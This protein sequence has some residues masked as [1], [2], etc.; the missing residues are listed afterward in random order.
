MIDAV[1][2]LAFGGPTRPEEIRPFLENVARG[3]NIPPERLQEVAR[4]YEM[5]PGGRSPL[6]ALT[7]AQ[8][9]ALSA[10]LASRG[11]ALPVFLGMRHWHPFIE[12]TLAA[13]TA[14]GRRRALA[15]IL[16]SLRTE[17]SWDRYVT[18][19]EEA[20]ARIRG[21]PQ[22]TFAPA[23]NEHAGFIAAVVDRVRRALREVPAAERGQTPLVFTAHSVQVAMAER[24]SYVEEFTRASGRVVAKLGH[25]RWRRAYQSRSGANELWLEPDV[26]DVLKEV[27]REGARHVVVVPIG[28]VVDHV[29]VLYDLDVEARAIARELGLAWHRAAAVND[30]HAFVAALADLVQAASR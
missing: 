17:A 8:A 13:M 9:R 28:F 19:V 6:R 5:M 7:E 20:R 24:S 26:G 14:H 1:L 11:L 23:W 29:E 21:A 27:A 15:I 25:A 10:A 18:D 3:R 4:H 30:H 2:L 22:V 12:E 16:S